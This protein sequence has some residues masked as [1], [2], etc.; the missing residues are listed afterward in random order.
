MGGVNPG[1][2][3]GVRPPADSHSA[4][5]TRRRCAASAPPRARHHRWW[6]RRF[7]PLRPRA[8]RAE[9]IGGADYILHNPELRITWVVCLWPRVRPFCRRWSHLVRGRISVSAS[10]RVQPGG[11][12]LSWSDI[13]L[14]MQAL[15][16]RGRDA[17]SWGS[18]ASTDGRRLTGP[19][20]RTRKSICHALRE[21]ALPCVST[22]DNGLGALALRRFGSGVV[23]GEIFHRF[24]LSRP[25]DPGQ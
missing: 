4:T 14:G 2:R 10:P 1:R 24:Q 21:V 5:R 9:C 18:Q 7:A 19:S 16:D 13:Q 17:P 8:R 25:G 23:V 12:Y 15:L 3:L 6:H 11:S 22:G 20:H